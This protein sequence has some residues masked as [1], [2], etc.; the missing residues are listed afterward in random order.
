MSFKIVETKMPE[1]KLICKG[2]LSKTDFVYVFKVAKL[3]FHN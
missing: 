3:Q 1:N 2:L